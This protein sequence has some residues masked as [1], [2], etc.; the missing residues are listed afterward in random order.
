MLHLNISHSFTHSV[1]VLLPRHNTSASTSGREN[2]QIP[3]FLGNLSSLGCTEIPQAAARTLHIKIPKP[4]QARPSWR[5]EKPTARGPSAT[6]FLTF[7]P[8][9]LHPDQCQLIANAPCKGASLW[10]CREAVLTQPCMHSDPKSHPVWP[11]CKS[12]KPSVAAS[13]NT[14]RQLFLS[15]KPRVFI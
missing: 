8:M 1:S 3:I 11:P 12:D 10:P 9:L 7:S 15:D 4:A 5:R 14:V 2:L 13:L 6:L